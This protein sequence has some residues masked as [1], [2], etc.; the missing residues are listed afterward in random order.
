MIGSA[1]IPNV[2]ACIRVLCFLFGLMVVGGVAMTQDSSRKA[3]LVKRF[4]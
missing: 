1:R 3:Q 2:G 4:P